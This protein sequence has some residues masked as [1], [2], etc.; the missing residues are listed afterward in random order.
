V[1]KTQNT[2]QASTQDDMMPEW[3]GWDQKENIIE[4]SKISNLEKFT[5]IRTDIVTLLASP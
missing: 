4:D 1:I 2:L 3:I 5:W